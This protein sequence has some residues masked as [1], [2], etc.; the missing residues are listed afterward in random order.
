MQD[1]GLTCA[2]ISATI[3]TYIS[4]RQ[5]TTPVTFFRAWGFG[6]RVSPTFQSPQEFQDGEIVI[7]CSIPADFLPQN[8]IFLSFQPDRSGISGLFLGFRCCYTL[9]LHCCFRFGDGSSILRLPARNVPGE[10]LAQR[11]TVRASP[12]EQDRQCSVHPVAP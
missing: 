8:L 5:N 1:L 3:V 9:Q 7:V 11:V 2:T 6:F 4:T 10:L 12:V